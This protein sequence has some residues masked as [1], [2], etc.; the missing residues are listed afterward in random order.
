MTKPQVV[1][2]SEWETA[3][4]E[5]L[6]K[7]KAAT[8]AME[9]L[10]AERRRLPRVLVEKNYV[11]NGPLGDVTLADMFEGRRQLIVY[12]FMYGPNNKAGC[13]GCSFLVDSVGHISHLHAANTTLAL[14]SHAPL[15]KLEAYRERMGWTLPWYSSFE[16]DFNRDYGGTTDR[17]EEHGLS[18]FI[19]DGD[20]IYYTYSTRDRGVESLATAFNWLDFTPLGRQEEEGIMHWVRR[21]DEYSQGG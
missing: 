21:H 5:L 17:G 11:L 7:E 4:S 18:V 12:H 14:V 16:S 8:R 3:R 10:H 13:D 9:A 2:L 15:P 6:V 20:D 1:S 19:R